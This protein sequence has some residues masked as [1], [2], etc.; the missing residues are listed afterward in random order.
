MQNLI[1][2]DELNGFRLFQVKVSS[3]AFGLSLSSK[4]GNAEK[5]LSLMAQGY[6]ASSFDISS[7]RRTKMIYLIRHFKPDLKCLC[8]K[9]YANKHIC[10]YSPKNNK[11]TCSICSKEFY[12]HNPTTKA[13]K[14]HRKLY[15]N[16]LSLIRTRRYR[17]KLRLERINAK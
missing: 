3:T 14:N 7:R 6:K 12:S 15:K 8:G 10:E 17:E 11:I 4:Y 16:R 9:P 13:C 2:E 5:I 1:S